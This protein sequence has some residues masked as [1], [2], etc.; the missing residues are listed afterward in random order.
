MSIDIKNLVS[1]RLGEN[2]TLHERY[3]NS[4]LVKVLR[5][6]GFDKVYARAKGQYLW[7][8]EDNRYLDYLSGYGVFNIGRNHPAV[9]Q[10]IRDV[11]D[12]DLPNM[13]QMDCAFLSGVMAEELIKRCPPHLNAAFFCNSGTE[14]VEGA[15]K[16]AK[17][18]T[19]RHR[20]VFLD[21]AFHGL[22][23][24]ALSVNGAESFREGFEPL[25]PG[26][27]KIQM[28]DLAALERELSKRDVAA[29]IFECCQGKMLNVPQPG[30][31][32][33]AQ[34]L[35]RKYGTLFISDEVQ[36]GMG[37][38]GKMFGFQHW[39]LE[40]D[41]ITMAKSLSGGYVPMGAFVTRRDIYQK[42]FSRMDR[43]VVHSTT[44]GRNN[45]AMACGLAALNVL[46]DEKLIEKGQK[47]SELLFTELNALKKKQS[48][49]K[50]VRGL[51]LMIGVE[52]HEPSGIK[53]RL[54]WKAIHA[55]DKALFPQIVVT[56]LFKKYRILTHVAAHKH[57]I[58]KIL[59][60]LVS[61]EEDARYFV[62]ALDDVLSDC[63]RVVGPMLEFGMSLAKTVSSAKAEVEPTA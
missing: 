49:I 13:V 34:E 37:R 51:G 38:T 27:V 58:I 4:T 45:L 3:V 60:P 12:M 61:T 47:V 33:A 59:P 55:A 29:F 11:L 22:T 21:H 32:P 31:L 46:E 10:V 1:K 53:A 50:D 7:D 24:G 39:N 16:F 5:T 54:A 9:Q 52:F 48:L 43:C 56:G 6:I 41:V 8:K 17:G 35:C 40:P 44:F 26:C 15:L 23:L 2:Y 19:G 42:V 20:M 30:F 28:N 14:A 57:D 63:D 62:N 36:T 25:L 18:A